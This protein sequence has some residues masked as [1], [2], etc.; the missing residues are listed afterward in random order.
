SRWVKNAEKLRVAP[1]KSRKIGCGRT[2]TYPDVEEELH[3][4]VVGE[5]KS[6][7]PVTMTS[8]KEKMLSLVAESSEESTP[9][10][11]P[12]GWAYGFMKC[13]NLSLR[14]FTTTV[15]A[16]HLTEKENA[17]AKVNEF[18]RHLAELQKE[19]GY[20]DDCI[21]NMDETPV[22]FETAPTR[23]IHRK[24][25]KEVPLSRAWRSCAQCQ[26]KSHPASNDFILQSHSES[27]HR[28]SSNG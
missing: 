5:R 24:G 28:S 3:T 16:G 19:Y 20:S 7:I 26:Q 10:K 21:I 22:W 9:F 1:P 23:T 14:S 15:K 8:L 11:A 18:R 25:D 2:V 6:G 12:W 27:E 13:F 17:E 4:D